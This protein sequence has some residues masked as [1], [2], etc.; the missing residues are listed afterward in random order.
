META[1]PRPKVLAPCVARILWV[2]HVSPG[3]ARRS[4]GREGDLG[5]L[6]LG[7]GRVSPRALRARPGQLLRRQ[8]S[9]AHP[10]GWIVDRILVRSN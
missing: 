5:E 7:E 8:A 6:A 2:P 10:L 4:V 1:V 3:R 9:G